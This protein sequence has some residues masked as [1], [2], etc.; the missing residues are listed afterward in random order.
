MSATTDQ[1]DTLPSKVIVELRTTSDGPN[2]IFNAMDNKDITHMVSTL[3]FRYDNG[4]Y[5]GSHIVWAPEYAPQ[6]QGAG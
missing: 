5:A 4:Q 6:T 1:H 2:R 3:M